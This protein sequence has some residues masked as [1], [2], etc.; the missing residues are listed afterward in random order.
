MPWCFPCDRYFETDHGYDQHIDNSAAHQDN[1]WECEFCDRCFSSEHARHQ[2]YSSAYSHPY[3]V[4]C[5]RTFM[6]ENNLMQVG[7]SRVLATAML[8]TNLYQAYAFKNPSGKQ[9]KVSLLQQL[10]RHRLR[11]DHPSRI[12][13]LFV[14]LESSQDQGNRPAPGPKQCHHSTNVDYA[15]L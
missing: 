6:N 5:K 2:H 13:R 15:W 9:F 14:W 1:D 12:W 3:C 10:I 4:S 7:A 8:Q 11:S